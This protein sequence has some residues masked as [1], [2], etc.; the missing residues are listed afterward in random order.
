MDNIID[1]SY[2]TTRKLINES[3]WGQSVSN[4]ELFSFLFSEVYELVDGCTN[5]DKNNIL[6]EA[7]D[8]LM[9]LLYIV[10]KN[11]DHEDGLNLIE[12][13]LLR[14][15]KKLRTRYSPFFTG[16]N[17]GEMEEE[18]WKQSKYLEKEVLNFLFCPCPSCRN[19][20]KVNR[21]NMIVEGNLVKCLS[22]G[23]TS[24]RNS[25]NMLLFTTKHRRNMFDNLDS[26]YVG[27]LMGRFQ[28]ANDYFDS[29]RQDYMKIVRYWIRSDVGKTALE[30]YFIEKHN[31]D[32]E[33]F[34]EFLVCPLR[35]YLK[36]ILSSR[37]KLSRATIEINDLLIK[38]INMNYIG[39][40]TMFCT[41][42]HEEYSR[43]WLEY[44][45][46]L[47]KSMTVPLECKPIVSLDKQSTF[48]E[49]TETSEPRVLQSN[50]YFLRATMGQEKKADIFIKFFSTDDAGHGTSIQADISNCR[51]NIQVGQLILS[52]DCKFNFQHTSKLR[53]I[54]LNS[55]RELNR[56]DLS[57]FLADLLP[58]FDVIEFQ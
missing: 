49:K 41:K 48:I 32:K 47:I 10:I 56:Q 40:K 17:N 19:Y 53:C 28:Y 5:N 9:I 39:M 6:E 42:E 18:H 44:I 54:L 27:F 57:E 58:K 8:V 52:V 1:I 16:E 22:C 35:N 38:C 33:S 21:G 14:L 7:S 15:N 11:S 31:A 26:Y 29:H 25:R 24:K 45:R 3:E 36:N 23:Y 43:I 50:T 55:R 30:D 13:L 12:E 2:E 51:S 4:K 20:A 34:E 37:K 46:Y